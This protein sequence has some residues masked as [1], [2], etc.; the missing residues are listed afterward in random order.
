LKNVIKRIKKINLI[1]S[2]TVY[3]LSKNS[4]KIKIKYFGKI[5]NLQDELTDNGFEFKILHNEWN[6]SLTS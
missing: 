5:K 6:L 4:A 3:E 2:Y 1:D